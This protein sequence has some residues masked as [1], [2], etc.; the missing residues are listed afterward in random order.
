MKDFRILI[1]FL[2]FGLG[3]ALIFAYVKYANQQSMVYDECYKASIFADPKSGLVKTPRLGEH[4][5]ASDHIALVACMKSNGYDYS[6]FSQ[7][8]FISNEEMCFTPSFLS[9]K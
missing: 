3:A 9:T 2:V 4:T 1:Q 7:C 5:P 6:A 8:S